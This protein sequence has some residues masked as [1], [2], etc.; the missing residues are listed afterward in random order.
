VKRVTVRERSLAEQKRVL[1]LRSARQREQFADQA[2]AL[3]SP[4]CSAVDRVQA[5]A[6]WLVGHKLAVFALVMAGSVGAAVFR[7][8]RAAPVLGGLLG[9]A[10]GLWATWT[11]VRPLVQRLLA[12]VS[13]LNA[14]PGDE[15]SARRR[16]RA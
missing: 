7:P 3:L 8:S 10:V 1:L 2:S 12:L 11:R 9:R 16:D 5:G 4:A 14:A 15:V 13:A 6:Q